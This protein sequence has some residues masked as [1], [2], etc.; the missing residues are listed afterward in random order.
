MSAA[1]SKIVTGC[2]AFREGANDSLRAQS[3][4]SDIG[5]ERIT[6][7]N[8]FIPSVNFMVRP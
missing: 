4:Q 7:E 6:G 5:S 8:G 2:I 1:T 3:K